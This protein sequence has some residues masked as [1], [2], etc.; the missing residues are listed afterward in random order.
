MAVFAMVVE[1]GSMNGAAKRLGITPSAVSQHIRRLETDSGV[2][3]LHRTTR[4][5]TLTTAG[6]TYYR[7]CRQML[8]AAREVRQRLDE[9]RDAPVGELRISAPVGF[10][11][12]ILPEALAPLLAANPGLSLE[13][14]LHDEQID[15]VAHRIDLAVRLGEQTPGLIARHLADTG[16]MLCAAPACLA[17]HPAIRHPRDL[18]KAQW[19]ALG[20]ERA[21]T[22]THADGRTETCRPVARLRSNSIIATRRFTLAGLGV[23]LQPTQEITQ[24]LA[25]G[26]LLPVLPDWRAPALG[27]F[28]VTRTRELPAR[29]RHAIDALRHYLSGR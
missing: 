12:M 23:S 6:S 20:E 29:V 2:A 21:V 7:G 11:G 16:M 28:A 27:V 10:G 18:E 15:L 14:L 17:A 19:L 22:L 3:L 4:K 9:M 1:E 25:S 26:R 8:E 13:L 24:E 5:L